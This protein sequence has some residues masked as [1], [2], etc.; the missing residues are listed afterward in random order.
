MKWHQL[1]GCTATRLKEKF[2][3]KGLT[4]LWF[5]NG[6][7]SRAVWEPLTRTNLLQYN[8][9]TTALTVTPIRDSEERKE[10]PNCLQA[11]T[12]WPVTYRILVYLILPSPTHAA[13]HTY[14]VCQW[15]RPPSKGTTVHLTTPNGVP[16][17]REWCRQQATKRATLYKA[18]T[19][20]C[21]PQIY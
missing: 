13:T 5:Y 18:L 20:C 11:A 10:H 8:I 1:V 17:Q 19:C 6:L 7:R 15:N 12:I 4:I 9:F 16:A 2:S 21:H 14:G 3:M